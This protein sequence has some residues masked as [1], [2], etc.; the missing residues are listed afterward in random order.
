MLP[1]SVRSFFGSVEW[2]ALP[3]LRFQYRDRPAQQVHLRPHQGEDLILP[4]SGIQGK[5]DDLI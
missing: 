3:I 4:H 1:F 2:S 5:E